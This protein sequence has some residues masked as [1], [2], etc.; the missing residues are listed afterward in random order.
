MGVLGMTKTLAGEVGKDNILA[1][2]LGPGRI[3]TDRITQ[4]DTIRATKAG[5]S[6]DDIRAETSR[7]IPLGRYGVP[8]EMAKLAVFLASPANTYITGQAMLVD[9]G[10][11]KSY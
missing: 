10:M 3:Q 9:G 8:E 7:T 6:T 4:L 2:V 1:N 11:V 5:K